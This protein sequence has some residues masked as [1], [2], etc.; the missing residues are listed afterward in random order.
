MLY[1]A[2]GKSPMIIHMHSTERER[3]KVQALSEQ[4]HYISV[5]QRGQAIHKCSM[6]I[7]FYSYK[8]GTKKVWNMSL[9]VVFSF[10][11]VLYSQGRYV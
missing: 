8:T 1:F 7:C 4:N 10:A 3:M 6:M 2:K 9:S 11:R 5:I